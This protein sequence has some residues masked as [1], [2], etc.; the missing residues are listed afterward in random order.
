MYRPL[1]TCALIESSVP[2]LAG[3]AAS[4]RPAALG[5]PAPPA[6]VAMRRDT[7]IGLL[8]P[9]LYATTR[10]GHT[11]AADVR[12]TAAGIWTPAI[13]AESRTGHHH[14]IDVDTELQSLQADSGDE[15][16]ARLGTPGRTFLTEIVS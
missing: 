12:H 15:S 5:V 7:D 14:L 1:L 10:S 16:V 11:T 8:T 4:G 9:A 2:W 13:D 6:V 3:S